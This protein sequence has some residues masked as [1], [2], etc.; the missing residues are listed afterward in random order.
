M[1]GSA[2]PPRAAG[3]LPAGRAVAVFFSLFFIRHC[4]ASPS[5]ASSLSTLS[6]SS[7]GDVQVICGRHLY[8]YFGAAAVAF[9]ALPRLPETCPA[10]SLEARRWFSVRAILPSAPFL[11]RSLPYAEGFALLP[12][13]YPGT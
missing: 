9:R 1:S 2:V 13:P 12:A 3:R 5:R 6:D 7:E 4:M 11:P 10:C 8:I